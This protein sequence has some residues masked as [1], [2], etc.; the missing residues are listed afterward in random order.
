M[1]K[2][3][4]KKIVDR[5]HANWNVQ[6]LPAQIDNIYRAWWDL[7]QSVD[8]E[9]ADTV[10]HHLSIEDSWCPRPGSVYRKCMDIQRGYSILSPARA[11]EEYRRLATEV[12]T[13]VWESGTMPD[14]LAATVRL[15]GGFHLHTN[16]DRDHFTQIY[17]EVI[18]SSYHSD[19]LHGKQ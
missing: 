6:P 11:W 13:G 12:D 15:V 3:E 19:L 7:L 17:T 1:T 5:V 16:S 14:E 10:I 18:N 8:Y 9:T 2:D 4:L